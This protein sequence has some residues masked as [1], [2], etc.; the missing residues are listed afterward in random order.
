MIFVT[1][2]E[3]VLYLP[4]HLTTDSERYTMKLQSNTNKSITVFENKIDDG[5][6]YY[7]VFDCDLSDIALGEYNYI[8]LSNN[9]KIDSG[10]I[11][12]GS[13]FKPLENKIQY[14]YTINKVQYNG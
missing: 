6:D 14:N 3:S 11:Q 9:E 2:E 10:L 12:I 13:I 4:K 8:L 7:Y 5:D 1:R